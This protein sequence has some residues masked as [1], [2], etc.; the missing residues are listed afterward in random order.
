MAETDTLPAPTLP[1][2]QETKW[3][4]EYR[5]FLGLLPELLATHRGRHVAIHEG[6]VVGVGDDRIQL[7]MEVWGK[8]GYVPIH[9]GLVTT[10][11]PPVE[12]VPSPRVARS[13]H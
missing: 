10:D 4:R 3:Q 13:D 6:R 2:P 11:P 12:R 5:A 9:I 8:Y 7:A 1:K